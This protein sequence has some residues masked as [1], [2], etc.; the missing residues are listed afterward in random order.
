[1]KPTHRRGRPLGDPLATLIKQK[2]G[3]NASIFVACQNITVPQKV[4]MGQ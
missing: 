4:P 1:M 2:D 3:A